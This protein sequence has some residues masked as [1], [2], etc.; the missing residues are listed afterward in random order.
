MKTI[1]LGKLGPTVVVPGLGTMGMSDMYGTK[2]TRNDAESI[3]T[4]KAALDMGINFLDTGDYYGMGHNELLIREALIGRRDKPVISVKFGALRSPSGDWLGFD[5]RPEAVKTFAAYS[6]NRLG[7]DAIDIYQPGRIHPTIPIEDTVGAIADLVQQGKVKYVGLSEANPN[8]IRRAH[9]VHPI[10]A[11]E[12]EYSLAS[13][14]IEKELLQVCRELGIGIV[15][16]GVLSRGLLSGELTGQFSPS[17]FRAHAPR[18]TGE[19]FEE[20][21]RKVGVLQTMAKDKG[22]TASQLALA[23]VMR[24]GN[25]ILPL[26]GTTKK[27]RLKENIEAAEIHLTEEDLS[28]LDRNFPEG[29]F[30]GTRYA[31]QQMGMVVN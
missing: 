2:E 3:E 1:Q 11:V 24:Q 21:K 20:N 12:V 6:L 25:D 10:T 15:A 14:F 19:N 16:Y 17:D 31:A 7:L 13:R 26:F 4:I 18:F 30:A 23:W 8:I 22:C 27:S 9:A 29:A 28:T 5:T